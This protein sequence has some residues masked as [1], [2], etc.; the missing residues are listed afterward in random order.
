LAG[1]EWWARPF[2]EIIPDEPANA[3][4][5][6]VQ[7]HRKACAISLL[8]NLGTWNSRKPDKITVVVKIYK[9]W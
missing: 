3:C 2:L 1:E 6:D 4:A 8:L 9:G 5:R 7:L